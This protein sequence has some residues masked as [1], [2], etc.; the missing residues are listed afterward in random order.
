MKKNIFAIF[1]FVFSFFAYSRSGFGGQMGFDFST[2]TDTFFSATFKTDTSPLCISLNAHFTNPIYNELKSSN[3][4][5]FS[6]DDWF[7]NERLAEHLDF[8]ILWGISGG[9]FYDFN[10]DSSEKDFLLGTGSR[11]GFGL[12]FFFF[13]R[14]L[15]F[16]TQ[17]VWNPFI[18][19]GKTESDFDVD[20]RPINFPCSI[21]MRIWN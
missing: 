3:T 10:C 5:T 8:Y 17:A 20:F 11:F 1:L 9:F 13:N 12:D 2:K 19:L 7:V 14:H 16:F 6:L 21:G 18:A 15:E 4:F